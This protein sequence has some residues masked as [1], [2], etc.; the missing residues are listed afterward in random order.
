MCEVW[1]YA[2]FA[3]IGLFAENITAKNCGKKRDLYKIKPSK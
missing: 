1:V 3:L 2:D